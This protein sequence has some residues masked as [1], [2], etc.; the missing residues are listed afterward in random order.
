[1]LNDQ[2]LIP[3][4]RSSPSFIIYDS[5]LITDIFL[6]ALKLLK[7]PSTDHVVIVGDTPWDAQGK[8]IDYDLT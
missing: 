5:F 4:F 6:A 1:M 8:L 7:N 2:N 3:V